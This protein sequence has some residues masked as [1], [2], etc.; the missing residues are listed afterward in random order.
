MADF[1]VESFFPP[2]FITFLLPGLFLSLIFLKKEV[3]LVKLLLYIAIF[4]FFFQVIATPISVFINTITRFDFRSI[5]IFISVVFL[6]AV[7][8]K[9][10]LRWKIIR[11]SFHDF[12]FIIFT[13][14]LIA[15]IS[16][17]I[18][19]TGYTYFNQSTDQYYW[20]ALAKSFIGQPQEISPQFL[21]LLSAQSPGFIFI[22]SPYLAF[23]NEDIDSYQFFIA[24]W[25]YFQYLL[26]ALAVFQLARSILP[27][28]S[29]ALLAPPIIFIFYWINYYLLYAVIVPQNLGIFLFIAGLLLIKNS[30]KF[31]VPFLFMFYLTNIGSFVM[32]I[33]A[34]GMI[35]LIGLTEVGVKT[36]NFKI[37]SALTIPPTII[38][39]VR[40]FLFALGL[41]SYFPPSTIDGYEEYIR[42]HNLFSQPYI[43][44]Y[45][46]IIIWLAVIGFI[47]VL[48]H[49]IISKKRLPAFMLGIIFILFY[50]LLLAPLIPYHAIKATWQKFRY[51]LF[52]YPSL[53]ILSLLPFAFLVKIIEKFISKTVGKVMVCFLITITLPTLLVY[54]MKQHES[55]FSDL[56][57]DSNTAAKSIT[58][59]QILNELML[60]KQ[61]IIKNSKENTL[62]I[63]EGIPLPYL[64][65]AFAPQQIFTI[66]KDCFDYYNCLVSNRISDKA[67]YFHNL[68]ID[69]LVTGKNTKMENLR[70]I[71]DYFSKQRETPNFIFYAAK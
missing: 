5:I 69:L 28:P 27:I 53:S 8:I 51:F 58:Y 34:I 22:I 35:S 49:G 9:I 39:L 64:Q 11:P 31:V 36:N 48:T 26:I 33:I 30:W 66:N 41:I 19:G 44:S 24:T 47:I 40:Y 6:L 52:L 32:F 61:K 45:S 38:F 43:N 71:V 29:L 17:Q 1:L 68:N 65:A 3:N 54:I 57:K 25:S 18:I 4:G 16:I 62:M 70:G 42:P 21:K 46:E 20:V 2:F 14:V 37:V 23:I 60:E 59:R 63:V 67:D 7:L 12:A 15:L 50:L 10:D 56:Y 13:I 55:L